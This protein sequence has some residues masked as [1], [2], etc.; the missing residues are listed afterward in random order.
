[1]PVPPA[2]KAS[3]FA[4]WR[5]ACLFVY[6]ELLEPNHRRIPIL[7]SHR[8]R[9]AVNRRVAGFLPQVHC[10]LKA[11]RHRELDTPRRARG[12]DHPEISAAGPLMQPGLHGRVAGLYLL[13]N[14]GP[15]EQTGEEFTRPGR[16]VS[17]VAPTRER[18][19]QQR[20]ASA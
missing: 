11:R 15:G 8:H 4:R 2:F 5:F 7:D 6:P 17:V 18:A 9:I 10:P 1:M 20:L 3:S 13:T 16:M 14:A 12:I 19:D